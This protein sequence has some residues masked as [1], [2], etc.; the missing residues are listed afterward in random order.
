[1]QIFVTQHAAQRLQQRLN[2]RINAN[3]TMYLPSN[4]VKVLDTTSNNEPVS[5][6]VNANQH[7]PAV[8]VV[9]RKTKNL[10]TVMTDGPSVQHAYAKLANT[11]KP[12]H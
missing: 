10:L 7:E 3:T 8:L 12:V 5:W 6:Y 1:M 9:S 11:N 2:V 4:F